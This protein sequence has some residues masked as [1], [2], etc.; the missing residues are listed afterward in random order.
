MR[1]LLALIF[2]IDYKCSMQPAFRKTFL[3]LTLVFLFLLWSPWRPLLCPVFGICNAPVVRADSASQPR[4][5]SQRHVEHLNAARQLQLQF[6][7]SAAFH[8]K[9]QSNL[10]LRKKDSNGRLESIRF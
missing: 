1:S 6:K 2:Y 3:V 10:S 5:K 9:L 7:A 4:P 8:L